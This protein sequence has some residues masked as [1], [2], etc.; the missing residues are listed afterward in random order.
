MIQPQAGTIAKPF[1]RLDGPHVEDGGV[2][3][4]HSL[5]PRIGPL[6]RSSAKQAHAGADHV[7][8]PV[9]TEEGTRRG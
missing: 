6:E 7:E 4:C 3:G 5:D 9:R 1:A 2:Q 8:A